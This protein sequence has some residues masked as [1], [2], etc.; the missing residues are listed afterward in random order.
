MSINKLILIFSL[1]AAP[2]AFARTSTDCTYSNSNR[3]PVGF[4]D[5]AGKLDFIVDKTEKVSIVMAP[6]AAD[7]DFVASLVPAISL[8]PSALALFEDKPVEVKVDIP[9]IVAVRIEAGSG[10]VAN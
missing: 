4:S 1:L 9:L 8:R 7:A 3:G 5:V 6:G 10:F 2:L